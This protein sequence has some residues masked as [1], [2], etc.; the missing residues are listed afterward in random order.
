M[1]EKSSLFCKKHQK[2]FL[3]Q[4]GT[5]YGQVWEGENPGRKWELEGFRCPFFMGVL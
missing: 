1:G 4:P 5:V 3:A 2:I